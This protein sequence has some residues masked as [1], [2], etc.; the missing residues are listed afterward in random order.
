MRVHACSTANRLSLRDTY[1]SASRVSTQTSKPQALRRRP[2]PGGKAL[3]KWAKGWKR[4]ERGPGRTGTQDSEE[5][6]QGVQ[7][8]HCCPMLPQAAQ[9]TNNERPLVQ[10]D[11]HLG[12]RRAQAEIRRYSCE[13]GDYLSTNRLEDSEKASLA[14]PSNA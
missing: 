12:H 6:L 2:R 1:G 8:A 3:P 13:Y 11:T 14:T 7:R 4:A 10:L 5:A 9:D